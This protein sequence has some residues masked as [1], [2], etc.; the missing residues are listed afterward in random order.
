MTKLTILSDDQLN[1]VVGGTG[2]G[3]A[4]NAEKKVELVERWQTKHPGATLPPGLAK[5]LPPP[6]PPAPTA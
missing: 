2:Q 4:M 3:V 5:K 6:P 1:F